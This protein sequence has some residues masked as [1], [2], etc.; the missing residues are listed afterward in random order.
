MDQ[1]KSFCINVIHHVYNIFFSTGSNFSVSSL[2]VALLIAAAFISF[3]RLKRRGDLPLP[4]LAR[5]LFPRR[6]LRH[7]SV[8][9]DLGYFFFNS[10]VYGGTFGLA[11]VSYQ[12]LTNGLLQG[13]IAVAGP[14]TPSP[15]PEIAQRAIVTVMLFLAYELGYWIDHY[16]KHRVPALWELHKV[17][18]TAE[19]LT[20][21]TTFRMHPLDLLVFGQIL[22]VTAATANGVTAYLFGD[23]TYQYALAGTNIILIV[24]I[25]LYV[26]LQHTHV[27]IAFR[28]VLGRIFLSPAHHQIHHSANPLH[29]NT[30]LGSCLAVWDWLFGT[31]HIPAKTREKLTFGVKPVQADTHTITGEFIAPFG[32][33]FA[34][35][36]G[37]MRR[38]RPEQSSPSPSADP[39]F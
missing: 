36:F 15:L 3:G 31:L 30:N 14:V 16:L 13:L 17:H 19:V 28:G 9:L 26:H 5:A 39:A 6:I 7:R 10:F 32:R 35:T 38:R 18:H 4:V 25:H 24:F 8:R 33:A 29:F 23:T 34:V 27:W 20:P 11:G 2:A 37:R 21:L 22:A 1:V 12:F